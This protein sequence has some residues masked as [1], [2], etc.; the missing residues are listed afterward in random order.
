M[1]KKLRVGIFSFTGDEGCVITFVEILNYKLKDWKDK[2]DFV[3]AR[4]LKANNTMN[5][6]DVAFVEGA[7]SNSK[8]LKLLQEI[9]DK[10][11]KVVAIGSC[12]I[13]GSP[14]NNRNFFDKERLEEIKPILE[15][16]S[17]LPSVEPIGKYIKVDAEVPGCPIIEEK[18]IQIMEN[19]FKEFGVE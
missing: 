1:G 11:K 4:I 16:F 12:A 7:I 14:S 10:A 3:Y 8:E 13:N 19:Y 5:D 6:L 17:H 9:R 2:V 15:R 18:F